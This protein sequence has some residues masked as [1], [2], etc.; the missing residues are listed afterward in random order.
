MSD[1]EHSSYP[2]DKDTATSAGNNVGDEI[3][4]SSG[5]GDAPG[6]E[7]TPCNDIKPPCWHLIKI[8][9][10]RRTLKVL[11]Y[12]LLVLLIL[13]WLVY[14]PPVQTFLKNVACN[15]AAQKTGMKISIDRFRLRFPLDISLDGIVVIEAKGDTMV[16]AGE[17]QVD[18]SLLPLLKLDVQTKKLRLLD[19]YYRMV[20]EDSSMITKVYAADLTAGPGTGANIPTGDIA[21][22]RVTLKGGRLDLYMNVWKQKPTPPQPGTFRITANTLLLENFAFNMSML[23]TIDTLSV[24]S[25]RVEVHGGVIDLRK[26]YIEV[27]SAALDCGRAVYI[28]PTAEY[29]K[30][31]PAPPPS[32]Y[33]S[34]PIVT[35]CSRRSA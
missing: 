5:N 24:Q 31:H 1:I 18:V 33:P 26:N 3:S 12:I 8:R 16:R 22:D 13:P 4:V 19:G 29:V 25:R 21:L 35:T 10:L 28:T 9:W 30:N 32:P 2:T 34:V 27:N 6:A 20:S 7:N 14:I 23:P 17:A 11:G 15:I